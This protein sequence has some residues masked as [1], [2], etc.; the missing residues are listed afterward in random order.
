MANINCVCLN[1][2]FA[3]A[4]AIIVL[5]ET[6][7]GIWTLVRHEQIDTLSSAQHEKIFALAVT[8]KKSIWDHMQSTV[9]I[10]SFSFFFRTFGHRI[11]FNW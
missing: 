11:L 4:L 5:I 1:S 3:I 9:K 8:D 6:G 7:V 10:A 2:Q